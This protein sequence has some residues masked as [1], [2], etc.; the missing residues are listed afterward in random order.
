MGNEL[1]IAF[2]F[3]IPGALP[4]NRLKGIMYVKSCYQQSA[5]FR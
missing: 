1:E 4:Q 5:P 2:T 3:I